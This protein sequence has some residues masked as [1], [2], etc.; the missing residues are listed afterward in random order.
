MEITQPIL[1]EWKAQAE[2]NGQLDEYTYHLGMVFPP[3]PY[4]LWKLKKASLDMIQA[5]QDFKDGLEIPAGMEERHI[6]LCKELG[7]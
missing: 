5:R 4:Q 6:E 7:Y 3:L 1:D 2:K